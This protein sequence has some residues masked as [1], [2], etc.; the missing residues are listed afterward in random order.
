MKLFTLVEDKIYE[1]ILL[2]RTKKGEWYLNIGGNR[3]NVVNNVFIDS[4]NIVNIL[5]VANLV[6][7]EKGV[8]H[9]VPTN[10]LSDNEK[11]A[12]VYIK[13]DGLGGN[14]YTLTGKLKGVFYKL[15]KDYVPYVRQFGIP[16]KD[17]Y[18]LEEALFITNFLKA[19]EIDDMIENIHDVFDDVYLY[20]DFHG[21]I[22]A[23]KDTKH[24]HTKGN[25]LDVLAIVPKDVWFEVGKKEKIKLHEEDFRYYFDGNRIC[26]GI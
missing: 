8:K 6:T 7:D 23:Y 22:L 19:E 9:L 21:K 3:L 26:L 4:D 20:Y 1:G 17:C 24:R 2:R 5:K 14:N 16:L 11:Y 25:S 10:R 15:Y 12:L 13:T 18:T